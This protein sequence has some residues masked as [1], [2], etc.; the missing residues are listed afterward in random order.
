MMDIQNTMQWLVIGYLRVYY[1][2]NCLN[3]S[4]GNQDRCLLQG[5]GNFFLDITVGIRYLDHQ[6][7]KL[8][9]PP[10]I[11]MFYSIQSRAKCQHLSY[12]ACSN[13]AILRPL[14]VTI[15]SFLL[16]WIFCHSTQDEH[17]KITTVRNIISC[18]A[19]LFLNRCSLHKSLG[20]RQLPLRALT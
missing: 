15:Q 3:C 12:Y 5:D 16:Q 10:N 6:N 14:F 13:K 7:L 8:I 19:S 18:S 11:Y 20:V 1:V 17:F 4:S 9:H 2:Q